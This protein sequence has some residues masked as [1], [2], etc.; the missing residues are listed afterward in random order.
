MQMIFQSG[1]RPGVLEP[2]KSDFSELSIL[3]RIGVPFGE[4][5][6]TPTKLKLSHL[7]TIVKKPKTKENLH[8]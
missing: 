7:T 5:N 3:F 2:T 6:S 8:S 4:L 1:L